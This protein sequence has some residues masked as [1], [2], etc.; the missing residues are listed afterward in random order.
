MSAQNRLF[1]ENAENNSVW[2]YT[3]PNGSSGG[4]FVKIGTASLAGR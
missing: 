1:Y 4:T 2:V 3:P